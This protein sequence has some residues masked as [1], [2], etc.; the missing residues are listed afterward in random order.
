MVDFLEGGYATFQLLLKFFYPLWGADR[1]DHLKLSK[2]LFP[3][4]LVFFSK[5]SIGTMKIISVV[6][7]RPQ[8]LK[9]FPLQK[10]FRENNVDHYVVHTGQHYDHNLS[11]NLFE[12]LGLPPPDYLL[13]KFG[14]TTS[15]GRMAHMMVEIEKIFIRLNPNKI[16]VFGDCDTT[17]AASLVANKLNI[18]LVHIE[19]GM[20]CYNR[21][22]PE[23][24]NRLIADNLSNLLLCSNREGLK[25]LEE[26][27]LNQPKF[28][29]GN[30]QI[31]LL[32]QCLNDYTNLAIIEDNKLAID[33]FILLTIHREA[34]TNPAALSRIFEE[35]EGLSHAI[36][37]PIHPRTS[38]IIQHN[39]IK[40]PSNITLISPVNY[41]DMTILERHCAY[42]V[43]DSGGVQPEA[44]YLQKKCIVMRKETEWSQAIES[45]NNILYDFQTPL[46]QFIQNF[47][48][49]E[50]KPMPKPLSA[51]QNIL[52]ILRWDPKE[53]EIKFQ[54]L[55][56]NLQGR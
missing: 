19:A 22:T 55:I 36:I 33:Q 51:A 41:L 23:E 31:D 1:Y 30:L 26:E 7:T 52:D 42:I 4:F 29:V 56:E 18:H 21:T 38:K 43:T 48:E 53:L 6:G 44:W 24:I 13:P 47:L 28:Y 12:S 16:I 25:N 10:V 45:N 15:I 46:T 11:K 27:K 14:K 49:V 34:N 5:S 20:R 3:A 50:A 37:F 2:A 17:V 39:N 8:F 9:L 40:I 54:S 35:L 32:K